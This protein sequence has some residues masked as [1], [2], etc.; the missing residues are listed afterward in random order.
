MDN[1]GNVSG[2][3]MGQRQAFLSTIPE[4][5]QV[6]YYAR[7]KRLYKKIYNQNEIKKAKESAFYYAMHGD[8]PEIA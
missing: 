8:A 5:I 6:S 2:Y 3:C 1:T 4:G 7:G